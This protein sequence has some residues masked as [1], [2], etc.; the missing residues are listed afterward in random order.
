MEVTIYHGGGMVPE[1]FTV[2]INKN[3]CRYIHWQ[4]PKTDTLPFTCSKE[5]LDQLLSQMNAMDFKNITSGESAGIV[6]DRPTTSIEFRY[7][8]KTHKVSVGATEEIKKGSVAN[9]N[10]LWS[11]IIQLAM[12]KTGQGPQR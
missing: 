6:Y 8:E 2:V 11:Y 9:F 5:E 3:A 4:Q 10:G 12:R 1:S 7:D